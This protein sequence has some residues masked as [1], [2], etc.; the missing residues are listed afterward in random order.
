MVFK[1]SLHGR[2][3]YS[4]R[5]KTEMEGEQLNVS[6]SQTVEMKLE[7]RPRE[8]AFAVVGMGVFVLTLGTVPPEAV[9]RLVPNLAH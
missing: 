9:E 1:C 5:G 8:L 4:G 3:A 7:I 6:V 2:I